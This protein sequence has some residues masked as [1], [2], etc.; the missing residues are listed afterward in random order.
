[1]EKDDNHPSE[2]EIAKALKQVK[3]IANKKQYD[4]VLQIFARD[5]SDRIAQAVAGLTE[6]D[7][8]LLLC[9]LMRTT[10][11]LAPLEQRSA[12]AVGSAAPDLLARFQPG[13]L[14]KGISASNHRGYQCFV[15]VKSTKNQKF[16]M[17]GSALRKLR[18]FA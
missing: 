1:M 12:I 5:Q 16:R 11:H 10:T 17:S 2:I 15:E 14:S 4:Q 18:D 8:F 13:Y 3:A 9:L 6:E 7:E